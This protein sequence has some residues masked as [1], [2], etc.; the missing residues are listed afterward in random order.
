SGSN[1]TLMDHKRSQKD[2][3]KEILPTPIAN[4]IVRFE[5]WQ[6]QE[7][8]SERRMKGD[9]TLKLENH[10]RDML[11]LGY[12]GIKNVV[13]ADSGLGE[14]DIPLIS[15]SPEKIPSRPNSNPPKNGWPNPKGEVGEIQWTICSDILTM[16][17]MQI[18]GEATNY[19]AFMVDSLIYDLERKYEELEKAEIQ[20][21]TTVIATKVVSPLPKDDKVF[22]IHNENLGKVDIFVPNEG[23]DGWTSVKKK[24]PHSVHFVMTRS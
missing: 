8:K 19:E 20:V 16:K 7:N 17:K 4:E 21:G 15:N 2:S 24:A 22:T 12:N 9:N 1:A 18:L 11:Q 23:D 13:L 14:A 3:S 10:C 6:G 5:N